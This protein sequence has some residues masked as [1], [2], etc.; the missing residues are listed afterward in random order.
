ME[1]HN[2]DGDNYVIRRE[3]SK[4]GDK[5]QSLWWVNGRT[6]SQK[7]V[8]EMA[9]RL[10]I[11][12]GNLVQFLP[13][14]KV[15]DFAR[16]SQVEL[17]QNTEKAVG[18]CEM[19]EL[20]ERLIE[21]CGS[22]QNNDQGLA[23]LRDQLDTEQQ[24][25]S[26]LEQDVKNFEQREK[27]LQRVQLLKMKR[28]WVEYVDLKKQFE[29][30]REE[31]DT[32]TTAF[33][34]ARAAQ[35]PLRQKMDEV[36]K[37]KQNVETQL[38]NKT[39]EIRDHATR[40]SECSRHLDELTD[41]IS[42]AKNDLDM[43]LKEEDSRARK[44]ADLTSQL[45]ALEHEYNQLEGAD[46]EQLAAELQEVNDLSRELMR[47]I[48]TIQNEGV[49]IQGQVNNLRRQVT[50]AQNQLRNIQDVGKHRLEQL[51]RF[52][53]H[54]YDAVMWL[55]QNRD[56]FKSTIHEPILLCLNM[57]DA[58][59]AKYVE[60]HISPNDMRAFVVE[61][62]DDLEQF[63]NIMQEQRLKVNA[64]RAPQQPLSSYRPNYPIDNVRKYGFRS[65]LGE[66]FTCPEAV[67]AFLCCL[68][69]VHQ[70]PV[71]DANT[72]RNVETVIKERPEITMF[73]TS[74]NQYSIKKSR[75]D[76]TVS[77]RNTPLKEVKFLAASLD[78]QQEQQ[79]LRT[80]QNT[81]KSLQ[82]AENQYR[83]L[84]RSQGDKDKE[85]NAAREKKRDLM[86]QKDAKKRV[87][88]QIQTKKESI[89][90]V[91][92]ERVDM[93]A[94][95]RNFHSKIS[96]IINKKC[97]HL[98]TMHLHTQRCF[99]LSKEKVRMSLQQSETLVKF[100]D[101]EAELRDASQGLATLE[102]EVEE[103]KKN[104]KEAKDRAREKLTEAKTAT[105]TNASEELSQEL[106]TAF[107]Q[108]PSTLTEL[109]D[110]IHRLQAC[111]DSIF[112]TD[113]KVIQTYKQRERKIGELKTQLSQRE[114]EQ[115]RLRRDLEDAKAK[116]LD[117]LRELIAK[118]NDNFGQFFSAMNCSGE[119]DLHVPENPDQF[120]KY[121]VRIRVKFR[122]GEQLRELTPFHQSGG[123]R[124][125]ATVLYMMSL[126]ELAKCPF[127]CVDEINQGMD[128]VNE[129]KVFELVVQTV[130]K[131]S[132]SQY[133]LL[134]PKLLPDLQYAD[135]MTVLCVNNGPHV[136]SHKDWN[137]QKFIQLRSS[138]ADQQN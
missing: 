99:E 23:T 102:R 74:D 37:S 61:D 7:S 20:H 3:I 107:E 86:R 125:V 110:E 19:Y 17:L 96:A 56:M 121:G 67:M 115:G 118:I 52:H 50:D 91:E 51:R 9:A 87:Q 21:M 101:L 53:R 40:V 120:D 64:V 34:K 112:Q 116:W 138:L 75:Y 49:Q 109:D 11:Q 28:P 27:F 85:L 41:K 124:S 97:E 69:R 22:T 29:K 98:A 127:R 132:A 54:T 130:C 80:I 59:D 90:R 2:D 60:T 5:V 137:L 122:D 44:L 100:S 70:I 8:E 46:A 31:R 42:D 30:V 103:L 65:Y 35:A 10:N 113:E 105:N 38:K 62:P 26:R 55:R 58:A 123:E 73:Y 88:Q 66:L 18:S 108:C 128:P 72:R 135:N 13:Q 4:I 136:L 133:F 117:P 76:G 92:G 15:A 12:V 81:Q 83:E 94:E 111:A 24:K 114:A 89:R 119:V 57:V 25:N 126:Q 39:T 78:V 43:K 106:R 84:Q 104:V 71:G 82:D 47:Q 32:K 16:M 45:T 77:S 93:A 129:R 6:A 48:N 1:L 79:L 134:T 33:N 36:S 95:E 131:R 14:E 68:Y 63:M